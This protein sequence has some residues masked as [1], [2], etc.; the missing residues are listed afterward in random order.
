MTRRVSLTVACALVSTSAL[1]FSTLD[2]NGGPA[3]WPG[4]SCIVY[5]DPSWA[6]FPA[7]VSE[8]SAAMSPWTA[9][10]GSNFVFTAAGASPSANLH[11]RTNGINDAYFDDLPANVYAVTWANQGGSNIFDRDVTFNT[12]WTWTTAGTGGVD[13]RSVAIHEFGHVLG[14]GHESAMPAVMRPYYVANTLERT[15]YFDDEEGCRFLYP[16]PPPPPPP[17][18]DS[19]LAIANVTFSPGDASSGDEVEVSFLMRNIGTDPTGLFAATVYLSEGGTVNPD[20]RF[21][22]A[23]VQSSLAPG[24]SKQLSLTVGLPDALDPRVYHVGAILDAQQATGDRNRNNNSGVATEVIQGGGDALAIGPGYRVT[25][26]LI[27][28]GVQSFTME[29]SAG[30]RIDVRTTLEGGALE[31]SLVQVATGEVLVKRRRDRRANGRLRVREDGTY[32]VHIS[33]QT[34]TAS[35]YELRVGAKTIRHRGS[36]AVGLAHQIVF[37][38]YR[39]STV[40][41]KIRSRSSARPTAEWVGIEAPSTTNK[42]GTKVTLGREFIPTT[43]PLVLALSQ[44]DGPPG[45]VSYRIRIRVPKKGLL[46]RR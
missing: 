16:A 7:F 8:L 23:A 18:S 40:K 10:S 41:A 32:L 22:G 44:G 21:L 35:A 31:L 15:L 29:L 2:Y 20:D 9:V 19:D 43:G 17:P 3:P 39:A 25:G 13:F 34:A 12:D 26:T 14:L 27:P 11:S 5:H 24:E 30:T 4:A 1:A 45:E 42:K 33:S 36:V 6:A 37:P 38:G 28:F 46:I